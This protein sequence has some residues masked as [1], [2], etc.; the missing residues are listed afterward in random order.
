MEFETFVANLGFDV[1]TLTDTQKTNLRNS[2][3]AQEK[4]APAPTPTPENNG[5]Y[6]EYVKLR[7]K[8]DNRR[9]AI[10][11]IG[12]KASDKYKSQ[13]SEIDRIVNLGLNSAWEPKDVELEILRSV[14]PEARGPGTDSCQV[15]EKVLE[16]GVLKALG[17]KGL[18]KDFDAKTLE[19]LSKNYRRGINFHQL[20][21]IVAQNNGM[22]RADI[23]GNYN[24][25]FRYA[26]RPYMVPMAATTSSYSIPDILS[27][28]QNKFIAVGI[29]Q[30]TEQEWRKI[31]KFRSTR[32]LKLVTSVGMDTDFRLEDISKGGQLATKTIAEHKYLNKAGG[33]GLI[34]AVTEE[35]VINDDLNLLSEIPTSMGQGREQTLCETFWTLWNSGIG[36]TVTNAKTGAVYPGNLTSTTPPTYATGAG[37]VFAAAGLKQAIEMG[38]AV[39]DYNGKP[40]GWK[41]DILV[42]GP[43]QAIDARTLIADTNLGSTN[44]YRGMFELVMSKYLANTAM[45]GVATRWALQANPNIAPVIEMAYYGDENPVVEPIDLPADTL[46]LGWRIRHY[47]GFALQEYRGRIVMK[48]AA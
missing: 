5:G 47:V 4:P 10:S 15:D 6:D 28:V 25:T 18:E 39:T 23:R 38:M 32:D 45:G 46:G 42:H 48:G 26:T 11:A 8:D 41:H 2:W 29:G 9:Q 31:C 19:T 22:A 33:Q 12:M 17:Y 27:N 20:F 14:R 34:F 24:E 35:D 1:A 40:V 43:S 36:S 30:W 7:E 21:D 44:V 13:R 37:T 3:R 16:A